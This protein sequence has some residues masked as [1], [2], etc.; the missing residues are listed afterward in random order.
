MSILL[1]T[2][3][4]SAKRLTLPSNLSVV[5][6]T[7]TLNRTRSRTESCGRY[8][9][10]DW[11]LFRQCPVNNHTPESIPKPTSYALNHHIRKVVLKCCIRDNGR[12]IWYRCALFRLCVPPQKNLAYQQKF[13]ILLCIDWFMLKSW[14]ISK[15]PTRNRTP[16]LLQ[17]HYDP[18][19][20]LR[21]YSTNAHL[22]LLT[23]TALMPQRIIVSTFLPFSFVACCIKAKNWHLKKNFPKLIQYAMTNCAIIILR[24]QWILVFLK[25]KISEMNDKEYE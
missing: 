11:S 22:G 21:R 1:H 13:K 12:R 20:L 14:L 7:N 10:C 4:S 6:S 15:S 25:F 18:S 19:I 8:T 3:V 23:K 24:G 17:M 9:A 2:F 5:S 16:L